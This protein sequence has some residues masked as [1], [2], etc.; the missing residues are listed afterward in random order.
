[1]A[2]YPFFL[3]WQHT[4]CG[5]KIVEV[6]TL[7][8]FIYLTKRIITKTMKTEYT[9][10]LRR[11][12]RPW[13][14]FFCIVREQSNKTSFFSTLKVIF[15]VCFFY[16]DHDFIRSLIYN[17]RPPFR[18]RCVAYYN[19]LVVKYPLMAQSIKQHVYTKVQLSIC[20]SQSYRNLIKS[21]F[22]WYLSSN[23]DD[24]NRIK[25]SP[26]FKHSDLIPICRLAGRSTLCV[27]DFINL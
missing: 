12:W 24:L 21:S 5:T 1:M 20:L 27:A 3:E 18:W 10:C 17:Q 7:T 4:T 14:M 23:N 16:D 11:C 2:F 15:C 13:V 25:K 8:L 22:R 19:K 9:Y 26:T 6:K